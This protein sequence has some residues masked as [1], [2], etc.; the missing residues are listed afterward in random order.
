MILSLQTKV[1][2]S[3]NNEKITSTQVIKNLLPLKLTL[4]VKPVKLTLKL[5]LPN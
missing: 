2:H 1:K 3:V 4:K 5:F